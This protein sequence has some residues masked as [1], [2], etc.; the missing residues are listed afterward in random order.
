MDKALFLAMSGAKQDFHHLQVR[1]NNLANANTSGFRADLVQARSMQAYGEGLPTRVF[2]MTEQTGFDPAQGSVMPTGR[3]LDLAIEGVG[4]FVVEGQNGQEAM[5]RQGQLQMDSTG[6]L[7][8]SQGHLILDE[9][10]NPIILP[11][12]I[13]HIDVKDD[14]QIWVT[15][16]GE[17]AAAFEVAK[18]KLVSP[19][20]QDI[21]KKNDG[22]FYLKTDD[23][24]ENQAEIS[25]LSGALEGSNVNPILEMTALVDLQ[26]HFEMQVKLMKQAEDMDT[27]NNRLMSMT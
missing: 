5:T 22:L 14:G 25:V 13:S 19:N 20:H 9:N 18:L 8:T 26:R 12:P 10:S 3:A 11:L 23:A 7:Q 15:L 2:A 17:G 27:S 24:L 16:Q 1:A 21:Q 4:W 6:L